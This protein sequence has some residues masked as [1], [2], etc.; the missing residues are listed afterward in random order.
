MM[1]VFTG[2]LEYRH[3][4][5]VHVFQT[6]ENDQYKPHTISN[7][8]IEVNYSI[9]SESGDIFSSIIWTPAD[10]IKRIVD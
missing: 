7:E 6:L 1:S 4:N 3:S 10:G 2:R 8:T 5:R 9:N